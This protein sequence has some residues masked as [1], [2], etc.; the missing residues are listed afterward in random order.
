V[1][2]RH[3]PTPRIFLRATRAILQGEEVLVS[4]GR[5]YWARRSVG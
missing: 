1:Y 2:T 3:L 5:G 4:Y